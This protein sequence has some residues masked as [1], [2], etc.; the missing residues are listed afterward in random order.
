[1]I[2]LRRFFILILVFSLTLFSVFSISLTVNVPEKYSEISAGEKFYFEL[3]IKYPEN[4]GRKD[5]RIEYRV[6]DQEGNLVAQSKVLKA[7]ETQASFIDSIS[8][9]KSL[10]NGVYILNVRILDY[11]DLNEE[12]STSFHVVTLES[13][14]ILTYFYILLIVILFVALLVLYDLFFGKKK[15]NV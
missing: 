5:L 10:S 11:Q 6:V 2:F 9:P 13:D 14:K 7:V 3:D 1:M 12:I 4:V 8:T 15:R